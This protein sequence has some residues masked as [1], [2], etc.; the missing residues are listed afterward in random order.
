M[1]FKPGIYYG[2]SLD[3]YLKDRAIN[4]SFISDFVISPI[5][6]QKIFI[7]CHRMSRM[8]ILLLIM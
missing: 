2:V 6:I 3:D 4:K 8:P 7:D 5:P 1:A